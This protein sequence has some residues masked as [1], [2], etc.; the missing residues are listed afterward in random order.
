MTELGGHVI[1][2][3]G[4][5]IE[6]R[7]FFSRSQ[8]R[9]TPKTGNAAK[10]QNPWELVEALINASLSITLGRVVHITVK[11]GPYPYPATPP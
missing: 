7:L 3:K 4:A 11:E 1:V 8:D 2:E 10:W 6:M 5:G 9:A